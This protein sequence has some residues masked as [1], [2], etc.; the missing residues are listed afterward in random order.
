MNSTVQL[1][2]AIISSHLGKIPA[3]LFLFWLNFVIKQL[4][5]T[6]ALF[7]SGCWRGGGNVIYLTVCLM[8]GVNQPLRSFCEQEQLGWLPWAGWQCG[9]HSGNAHCVGFISL[10]AE[11]SWAAF[12]GFSSNLCPEQRHL[13]PN[14]ALGS[15]GTSALCHTRSA[16]GSGGCTS[17]NPCIFSLSIYQVVVQLHPGVFAEGSRFGSFAL[18]L[19]VQLSQLPCPRGFLPA[20]LPASFPD[21]SKQGWT[22]CHAPLEVSKLSGSSCCVEFVMLSLK[23]GN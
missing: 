11:L 10:S 18:W 19:L 9:Q 1:V 23:M 21:P 6:Q 7:W 20:F 16:R 13:T 22:F 5:F 12:W 14:P 17:G 2:L 4:I 8:G 3:G 15:A